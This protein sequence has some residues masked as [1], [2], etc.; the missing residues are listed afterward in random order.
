MREEEVVVDHGSHH[1][2]HSDLGKCSPTSAYF[3]NGDVA[4]IVDECIIMS[5]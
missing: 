2:S 4:I 3:S 5:Y 1:Q